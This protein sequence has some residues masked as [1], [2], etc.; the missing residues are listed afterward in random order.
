MLE[1]LQRELVESS[2]VAEEPLESFVHWGEYL[3]IR[4]MGM[5]DRPEVNGREQSIRRTSQKG[6]VNVSPKRTGSWGKSDRKELEVVPKW[7]ARM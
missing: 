6:L 3:K 2:M 7:R 1:K 4:K 5:Q